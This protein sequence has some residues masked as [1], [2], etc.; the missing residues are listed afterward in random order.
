MKCIYCHKNHK[1]TTAGVLIYISCCQKIQMLKQSVRPR[2]REYYEKQE[3]I[4][5]VNQPEEFLSF[6]L[7]TIVL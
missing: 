2:V 3:N 1:V 7:R 6:L 4:I 5:L